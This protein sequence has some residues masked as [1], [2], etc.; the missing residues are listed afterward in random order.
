MTFTSMWAEAL[1]DLAVMMA[2]PLPTAVTKP[3]GL[4]VAMFSSLLCQ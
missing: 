2:V 4:T 1:P 3:R